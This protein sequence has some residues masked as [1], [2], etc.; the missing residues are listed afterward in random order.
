MAEWAFTHA[1]SLDGFVET[2][3]PVCGFWV[4]SCTTE[5]ALKASEKEH[6]CDPEDVVYS[7][8]WN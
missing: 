4:A 7:T 5:G 8:A 3:C 1:Y 2:R 6:E